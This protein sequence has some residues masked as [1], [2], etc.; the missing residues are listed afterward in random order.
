MSSKSCARL[1]IIS[2]YCWSSC[3]VKPTIAQTPS[4]GQKNV[5]CVI[6]QY[7]LGFPPP[8]PVYFSGIFPSPLLL[9]CLLF[10]PFYQCSDQVISA[11]PYI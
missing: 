5:Y 10:V 8:P 9:C 6:P 7:I 1:K 3:S 4:F 11:S 2:S